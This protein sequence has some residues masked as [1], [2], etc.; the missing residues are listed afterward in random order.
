MLIPNN[1]L[2]TMELL[3]PKR[4]PVGKVKIDWT[5][6]LSIGLI[7]YWSFGSSDRLKDLAR[8]NDAYIVNAPLLNVNSIS[9]DRVTPKYIQID[10]PN[11]IYGDDSNGM[12]INALVRFDVFNTWNKGIT[13]KGSLSWTSD[14]WSMGEGSSTTE[15]QYTFKNTD[16]RAALTQ[17]MIGE[18]FNLTLVSRRGSPDA[19]E[20]YLEGILVSTSL[21]RNFGTPTTQPLTIG[22]YSGEVGHNTSMTIKHLGIYNRALSAQEIKFLY[23]SPYQ[24]L[25][26][27]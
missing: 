10:D 14:G 4:K 20:F 13:K 3:Y 16:G 7:G 18:W 19:V 5:H 2:D 21:F 1:K 15:L 17:S 12:T 26:P 24:F 27:A 11:A 8:G 22:Q 9:T 6:P 23:D 25:M